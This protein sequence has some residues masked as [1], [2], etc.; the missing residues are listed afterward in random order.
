MAVRDA[1]V[2]SHAFIKKQK[3]NKNTWGSSS[4][5]EG[6]GAVSILG[7]ASPCFYMS[8]LPNKICLLTRWLYG[9]K[10]Y[11]ETLTEEAQNLHCN[12]TD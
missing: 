2:E 5:G 4:R 9:H 12:E 8:A 11:Y 1:T 7:E 6:E 10:L 3:Q